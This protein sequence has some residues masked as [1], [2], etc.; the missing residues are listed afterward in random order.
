MKAYEELLNRTSKSWAPWYI[1]PANRKWY[2]NLVIAEVLV[3]ALKGLKMS[4]PEPKEDL[5]SVVIE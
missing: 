5:S 2:R 1:V 4:Y 3:D